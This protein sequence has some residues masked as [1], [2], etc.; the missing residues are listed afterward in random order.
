MGGDGRRKGC[1]IQRDGEGKIVAAPNAR[2]AGLTKRRGVATTEV[3]SGGMW[4]RRSP[5]ENADQVGTFHVPRILALAFVTLLG[6]VWRTCRS[7]MDTGVLALAL[8]RRRIRVRSSLSTVS[9]SAIVPARM[10]TEYSDR[11]GT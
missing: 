2:N 4:P 10:V 6:P 11:V 8:G 1:E 5:G 9:I 3:G 7:G